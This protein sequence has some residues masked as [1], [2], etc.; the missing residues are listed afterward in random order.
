MHLRELHLQRFRSFMDGTVAFHPHLTALVGE[1]NGG[2]SN[3]IDALRLLV[4]PM[5]GRRELYCEE[6]DV[7]R[8]VA[9]QSF[10]LKATFD[11]LS[12]A[13]KGLLITAVPD[14]RPFTAAIPVQSLGIGKRDLGKISRYLDVTRSALVFGGRVLLL[15]GI[16]EALLLPA[17]AKRLF[18]N[19]TAA[20]TA[21]HDSWKRFQGATMVAIDGVDFQPYLD[22]LLTPV[23][24][25]TLP[26]L[27]PRTTCCL[28]WLRRA[29]CVAGSG[30]ATTFPRIFAPN[31]WR[32]KSR[33]RGKPCISAGG[34]ADDF[35]TIVVRTK[36]RSNYQRFLPP[37]EAEA[38]QSSMSNDEVC[39]MWVVDGTLDDLT[40][41][42]SRQSSFDYLCMFLCGGARD[43]KLIE[44]IIE[45]RREIDLY[46]GE[47]IL[48]ALF[49]EGV[50][51][52]ACLHADDSPTC[53]PAKVLGQRTKSMG[54]IWREHDRCRGFFLG[55]SVLDVKVEG[56]DRESILDA[57]YKATHRA[58]DI[59]NISPDVLPCLL[60][61]SV[62][63][64]SPEV[65]EYKRPEEIDA[66][67]TFFM[68]AAKWCR[69]ADELI[70]N[71]EKVQQQAKRL[72][73]LT[74]EMSP[75]ERDYEHIINLLREFAKSKG[76]SEPEAAAL[77]NNKSARAAFH[78]I[79]QLSA[80][81]VAGEDGSIRVA[82]QRLAALEK[83]LHPL[84]NE[85]GQLIAGKDSLQ[86]YVKVLEMQK[87]EISELLV[88]THLKLTAMK[89]G[90][91]MVELVRRMTKINFPSVPV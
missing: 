77:F 31:C 87:A 75:L 65:V 85:W 8:G 60:L 71:R 32:P 79:G 42:F 4:Q 57:A 62:H 39:T 36:R 81:A 58:M 37:P 13:Q 18:S 5:N 68:K 19:R 38:A 12:P 2:K 10:A 21:D 6:S 16:A 72:H 90:R 73:E 59:F 91:T 29:P 89:T 83:V 64:S 70:G 34:H 40:H 49:G 47:R 24:E 33:R 9:T 48:F 86:R 3:V 67:V 61:F 78:L 20:G 56:F 30:T 46:T 55:K 26:S 53:L 44:A 7:R 22:L 63:Q 45:R 23:G 27:C 28:P 88:K 1:N 51:D 76:C 15:E 52:V 43:A 35:R 54:E 66:I 74:Q 50:T 14:P 25:A 17:M 84:R 80:Q 41:W 11:G 69:I 82:A